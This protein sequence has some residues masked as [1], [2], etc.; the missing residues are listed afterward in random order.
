MTA[1]AVNANVAG[2]IGQR[3]ES[4]SAGAEL[5]PEAGPEASDEAGVGLEG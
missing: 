4:A 3:P 1:A 2:C 5:G